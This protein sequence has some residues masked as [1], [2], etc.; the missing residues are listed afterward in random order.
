MFEEKTSKNILNEMLADFER[1]VDTNPGSLA[2]NA[3]AKMA[4]Q[5]EEIYAEMDAINDNMAPDRQDI[6]HLIQWG[7]SR[8]TTY[9]YATPPTVKGQF[10]QEIEIGEQFA[11]NDYTYT[12]TE[13]IGNNAYKLVCDVE[14]TDAN[15][16]IGELTPVDYVDDYQGGNIVEILTPGRND[17]ETEAYR[18]RVT[19]DLQVNP[20]GGNKAY[21]RYYI[22]QIPGVGG[23]KPIRRENG[24]GYEDIYVV[25]DDLK[26]ISAEKIKEIQNVVDPGRLGDGEGIATIGHIINITTPVPCRVDVSAEVTCGTGYEKEAC[27][28]AA[29]EAV[30]EYIAELRGEWESNGEKD[31]TLRRSRV[32]SI[33]L[34]VDGIIDISNTKLNDK[35]ENAVYAYDCIPVKA[36][37]EFV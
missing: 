37:V 14:G 13:S 26:D 2:Y 18:K 31:L 15:G 21:Y 7:E 5:L 30:E 11:C 34:S 1:G 36:V 8:G 28:T 27:L 24:H 9:N 19:S 3:C 22:N 20:C 35:E 10:K 4:D 25:G 6:A 12:V 32:E 23:C 16:N 33:I 29:T 17:E